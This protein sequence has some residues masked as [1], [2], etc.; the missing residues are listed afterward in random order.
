MWGCDWNGFWGG[1]GGWGIGFGFLNVFFVL[2]MVFVLTYACYRLFRSS[3]P[4]PSGFT[5]QQDSLHILKS[6]LAR[7]EI[8]LEEYQEM[9]QVLAPDR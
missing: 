3:R 2:L 7:G 6:R 4:V 9:H 5:D 8:S 1:T